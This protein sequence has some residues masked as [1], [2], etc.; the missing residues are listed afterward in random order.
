MAVTAS[1]VSPDEIKSVISLVMFATKLLASSPE[2]TTVALTPSA[3]VAAP[4]PS[5][6][7]RANEIV[8]F[9]VSSPAG[10]VVPLLEIGT[11]TVPSDALAPSATAGETAKYVYVIGRSESDQLAAARVKMVWSASP[12][13]G[14][15]ENDPFDGGVLTATVVLALAIPYASTTVTT[16]EYECPPERMFGLTTRNRPADSPTRNASINYWMKVIN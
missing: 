9:C 15:T 6:A 4:R 8:Q 13:S 12:D 7:L 1:S 16:N 2:K 3:Y 5:I 11:R 14:A 10:K